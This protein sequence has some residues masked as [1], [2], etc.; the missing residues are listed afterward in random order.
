MKNA[1]E[2]GSGSMT[3]IPGFIKTGSGIQTLTGEDTQTGWKL[4]KP[5]YIF[6]K[7]RKAG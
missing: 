5:T 4:H 2:I 3:Y 1:V 6:F 7:R